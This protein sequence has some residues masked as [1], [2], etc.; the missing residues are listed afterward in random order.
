MIA[1][2]QMLSHEMGNG[3]GWDM[4]VKYVCVIVVD[5][6]WLWRARLVRR[7]AAKLGSIL[8][9]AKK[10]RCPIC[11]AFSRKELLVDFNIF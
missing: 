6:L 3:M 11:D 9:R 1:L 2:I 5:G 4:L 7:L 10:S 8:T